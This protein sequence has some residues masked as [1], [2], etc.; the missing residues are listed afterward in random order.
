MLLF[1]RMR[2]SLALLSRDDDIEV[3]VDEASDHTEDTSPV[4]AISRAAT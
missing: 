1:S 2:E 4:R 3:I